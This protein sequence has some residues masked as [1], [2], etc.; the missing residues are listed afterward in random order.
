MQAGEGAQRATGLASATR[1]LV[2]RVAPELLLATS[3][4]RRM[5]LGAIRSANLRIHLCR[6][7]IGPVSGLAGGVIY[8]GDSPRVRRTIRP[9]GKKRVKKTQDVSTRFTLQIRMRGA[10]ADLLWLHYTI[11]FAESAHNHGSAHPFQT[12][13]S[14]AMASSP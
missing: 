10:R 7:S 11:L 1:N 3:I 5:S 2:V 4:A 12:S 14:V 8:D 13:I 9:D 6:R